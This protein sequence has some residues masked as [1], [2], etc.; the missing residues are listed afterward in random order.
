[1]Y[2]MGKTTILQYLS[3]FHALL[4]FLQLRV[5]G[6]YTLFENIKAFVIACGV[7]SKCW[8]HRKH[9]EP[10]DSQLIHG[11]FGIKKFQDHS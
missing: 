1:M 3:R 10:S 6:L 4:L 5:E 9:L 11:I 8:S 7:G 2:N